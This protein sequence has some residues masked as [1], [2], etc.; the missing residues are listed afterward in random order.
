[1]IID[2]KKYSSIKIGQP[3]EVCEVDESM[4]FKGFVVGGAN[5]LLISPNAKNLGILSKKYDF[6]E[7]LDE[8]E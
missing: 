3:C 2:F 7:I 8:N 5:N 1:M 4:D 6:I